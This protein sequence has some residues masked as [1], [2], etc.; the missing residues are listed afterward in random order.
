MEKRGQVTIFIVLGILV[1][2]VIGLLFYF[3]G[4]I[5]KGKVGEEEAQSF[6]AARVE[7]VK[8]V[9]RDCVRDKLMEGIRLVSWQGGY[10]DPV[11]FE[12]VCVDYDFENEECLENISIGYACKDG[13]NT[14]PLVSFIS[15]EIKQFMDDDRE[16]EEL[17]ACIKNSFDRFEAEGLSL[18]YDFSDLEVGEPAILSGRVRQSI[19]FPVVISKDDYSTSFD[20]LGV[21]L[22]SNLLDVY[23][24][25]VDIVNTECGGNNF[26]IDDYVWEHEQGG[27]VLAASIANGPVSE[28]HRGWY[29]ESFKNEEDGMPLKFHF[30]IEE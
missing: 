6:V 27:D 11:Y 13:V 20:E 22:K 18:G 28:G 24:I 21:E 17:E 14:L 10:F 7:P 26:E 12:S 16:R 30:M 3:R 9:V 1:L 5:F 25:A 8:D 2:I 23:N 4:S 19:D 15:K 29:L